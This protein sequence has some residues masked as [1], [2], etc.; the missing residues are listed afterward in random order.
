M[1]SFIYSCK[2]LETDKSGDSF[3]L[4][5]DCDCVLSFVPQCFLFS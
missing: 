2:Q 4:S 3:N 5:K 1:L